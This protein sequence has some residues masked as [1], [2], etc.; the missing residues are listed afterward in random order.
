MKN[1]KPKGKMP[2][3]IGGTLGRP[4]KRLVRK[5]SYCKRCKIP[6]LKG[7]QCCEIPQLGGGFSSCRPYCDKCFRLILEQTKKDL[8]TLF[9]GDF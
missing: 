2:S 8:D 5:K 1:G 6:I 4:Q 7:S 3:L 9:A